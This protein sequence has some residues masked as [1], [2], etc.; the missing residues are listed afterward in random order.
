MHVMNQHVKEN[1]MDYM[2]IQLKDVEDFLDV[3]QEK[4]SVSKIVVKDYCSMEKCV[5]ILNV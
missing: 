3:H 4:Q 5:I 1:Q 2:Q